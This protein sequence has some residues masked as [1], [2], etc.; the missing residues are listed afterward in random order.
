MGGGS[1]A[2]WAYQEQITGLPRVWEC[3]VG[4]AAFDGY[5][6]ERGV[7]LEAKYNYGSFFEANGAAKVFWTIPKAGETES[8]FAAQVRELSREYESSGSRRIEIHTN[9]INSKLGFQKIIDANDWEDRMVVILT[10]KIM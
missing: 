3:K 9:E 1:E 5:D 2:S 4:T 7:Y 10:P 8:G 6:Y